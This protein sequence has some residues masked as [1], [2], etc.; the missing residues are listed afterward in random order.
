MRIYENI[1]KTSENRLPQRCY[2]IPSGVSEYILLN[3]DWNFKYFSRDIDVPE[4]INNW[5]VITVPSCW[6]TIG[7]ENPNYTNIN[8]PF[9][10]DP[11]F[12]P[13]D[14]PCG[15]YNREFLI[16]KVIGKVYFVF[17]GVSSCAFLYINDKYVGFTQGSHLQSEFDI[18]DFVKEGKNSVT[19]KV[20]KWCVGSY[21]EDQDAFR[22]HGIFRDVY[23]LQRP[24]DHIT[25][26]L[27][28]AKDGKII[29]D[30]GKEADVS[31]FDVDGTLLKISKNSKIA[32]F[33]I[34]N[35]IYWNAEK[36]LLY[37][38]KIIRDGEE[39]TQKTA[40]RDISI[41]DKYEL[42]I[43]GVP[44]KLRGVNHHDTHP[45]FGWYQ[46]DEHLK[47]DLELMKEL[48]INC[49]RTSHYPPTPKF[50]D[51]CDEMGFYVILETD[52]ELH[53]FVTR[54]PNKNSWSYDVSSGDWP[55]TMPEWEKEHIE[56][57]QR[58][59]LRDRNH[60]SII[61]WSTGN[62]S[63]HGSNHVAMIEWARSLNDGRL[64][65]CEDASR[66]GEYDHADVF[67]RMYLSISD[68]ESFANNQDIK[69]PIFLCEY[70]HAMGNGPGDVWDYNELFD[71][72]PKYAGGCIWEWTDHTVLDEN[73]VQLYGGDFEGELTN[74][75]NF[76]CDGMVFSD[77]S[78][79]GG[80]LEVKAAYQ[81]M[82]TVLNGN[83]V[84]VIN[85][86]SFTNLN[87]YTFKYVIEADGVVLKEKEL[88]LDV[89]GLNSV[90]YKIDLEKI[91]CKYGAYVN[92][93]LIK[94]GKEVAHTQHELPFEKIENTTNA[95]LAKLVEDEDSI[96]IFGDNFKYT[97][98][99][100]YGTLISMIVD[101]QEQL[102]DKVLLSSRFAFIDNQRRC[103]GMWH[104]FANSDWKTENILEHFEKTY[105][106][107]I[108]D[109]NIL[110]HG[111]IA[112]VS[113]APYFKYTLLI[114]PYA[115][116]K[117]DFTL[118]GNIRPTAFWLP[119]LGFEFT[120][121][122]DNAEFKYF[123]NGPY[124]SYIDMCHAGKIGLYESSA[125]DEYI[126]YAR[127][128]EHGNHTN[129]KMLQIG[130]LCFEGDSFDC[131]VS[132]YNIENLIDAEHTDELFKDGKTHLRI[133]YK[134]SGLG[135]NSCGPELDKKYCLCEKEIDFKF[136][137]SPIFE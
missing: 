134:V 25:D 12:V 123:G 76:C 100:H 42:L 26:V 94:D 33:S 99:K 62:E 28:T 97:I 29:V 37:T 32:E 38:V 65:H 114:T 91:S 92:F 49:I 50:L 47:H 58:A 117:L 8:Y 31:L 126:H 27:I 3:G 136:S 64:I 120:L 39:I 18:T 6:Q 116:G 118:N 77:R 119:R 10:V 61:M 105:S 78:F 59:V 66:K 46:P 101:S 124:E 54:D 2:Y 74:D 68:L 73:G 20:L 1:L 51:M 40:F 128:Q 115:D 72:N 122:Q 70:A 129:T 4:K 44:V 93:Y 108:V 111:A 71:S 9:P 109:G 125:D 23:I 98:S 57:M 67:S 36:P 87:D 79:K 133:D 52:I 34:K 16:D 102:C 89:P 83:V 24:I 103:R 22:M 7:V 88:I 53:G 86:L 41:S 15:V 80:S 107:E 17:E 127:P 96:I 19:V 110:V 95:Q 11:P 104:K 75:S 5:D 112:G 69:M 106:C 137:I 90:E 43:N 132:S 14:N 30:C 55:C 81:P 48:N 113:R 56:R 45:K 60:V 131:N 84:T 21:L 135:S 13:D 63:G 130:K 35:P 85:R 82:R 121:P